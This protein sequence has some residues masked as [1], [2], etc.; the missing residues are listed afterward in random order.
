M[1]QQY[2]ERPSPQYK[3]CVAISR[4]AFYYEYPKHKDKFIWGIPGKYEN[5]LDQEISALCCSWVF[6]GT[7]KSLEAAIYIDSLFKGEPFKF[8]AK[9]EYNFLVM[10]QD[11]NKEIYSSITIKDCYYLFDWIHK[12]LSSY[13]GIGNA[14]SLIGGDT[15]FDKMKKLVKGIPMLSMKS[16]N[17]DG[18][19]NL[20]L[21]IMSHCL[22]RYDLNSSSLRA[23][24]FEND[25]LPN[26]REMT[27]INKKTKKTKMVEEVTNHLKW[28]S[29]KY[30][31]TFW[32]GIAAYKEY[33]KDEPLLAKKFARMKM[34]RH[35]FKKK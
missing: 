10:E 25:I 31:M 21:F 15:P 13:Q 23:P 16:I 11:Q 5:L 14:M 12:T 30:P 28:F 4:I 17:A 18:K 24:L 34:T 29:E 3:Y 9:K 33:K 1:K 19:V 26:C 8:I 35:N 32:I 20:F 27:I 22:E 6:D 7:K 2:I